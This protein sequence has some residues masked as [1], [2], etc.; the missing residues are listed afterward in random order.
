MR[1]YFVRHGQTNLNH[2]RLIQGRFDAPLNNVGKRQAKQ[3]GQ[4]L[5][6]LKV[7]YDKI[8]SSPLSRALET[9]HLIARKINYK[10]NIFIEPKMIE[11]D[12]GRFEMTS[13]S[14]N[15]PKIMQPN[16]KDPGYED[17]ELILKRVND[18]LISLHSKYA[19]QNIVVAAHAHVIRSVYI[20]MDKEKYNYTNF[21]LGNG[22]IH[23]FDFDG[24]NIS[25]VA[26][27]LNEEN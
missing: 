6:G 12:F 21:F 11:R 24:K 16:F 7:N 8:V 13:I 9:A 3:A 5:K 10:E 23:V 4:T 18:G 25:L 19:N 22:S 27:Y 2:K 20:L 1:L 15:F 17:D 14:D 26:T